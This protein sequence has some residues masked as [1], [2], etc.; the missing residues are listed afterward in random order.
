MRQLP[1]LDGFTPSCAFFCNAA[2]KNLA[3]LQAFWKPKCD[4]NPMIPIPTFPFS[5]YDW[6]L[7]FVTT[8]PYSSYYLMY[9]IREYKFTCET[10]NPVWY[11]QFLVKFTPG[12]YARMMPPS[13]FPYCF[14]IRAWWPHTLILRASLEHNLF[15]FPS[16]WLVRC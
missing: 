2:P 1:N 6:N 8:M 16:F 4:T 13:N 12:L 7:L 5:I 11:T 9:Y 14:S 10:M 3:I 15:I